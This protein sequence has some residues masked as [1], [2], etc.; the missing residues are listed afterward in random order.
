MGFIVGPSYTTEQGIVISSLYLSVNFYRFIPLL[1]G[2]MQ[3]VIGLSAYLSRDDKY[4]GS[5]PF[6]IP[7]SLS[8]IDTNMSQLEFYRKSL[9]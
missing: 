4:A 8:T 1:N 7:V 5:E 6:V 3:C 2:T 9:Y